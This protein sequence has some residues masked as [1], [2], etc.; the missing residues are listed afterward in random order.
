MSDEHPESDERA[1]RE[2]ALSQASDTLQRRLKLVLELEE[3]KA[4]DA[5]VA[6]HALTEVLMDLAVGL[7]AHHDAYAVRLLDAARAR[8]LEVV[9][10]IGGATGETRH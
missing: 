3:G 2:A 10:A 7:L 4:S 5:R 6:C 1:R 8:L 9:A